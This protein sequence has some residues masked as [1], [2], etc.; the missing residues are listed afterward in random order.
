MSAVQPV[1]VLSA[2]FCI[3]CNL[4]MFVLDTMGD[5]TVLAYSMIGLVMAL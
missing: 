4:V 3:V 5:Q 1:A 2:V